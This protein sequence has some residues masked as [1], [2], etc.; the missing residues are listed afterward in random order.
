ML[1]ECHTP[2]FFR[3]LRSRQM[4]AAQSSILES[5]IP[6]RVCYEKNGNLQTKK[7]TKCKATISTLSKQH[8]LRWEAEEFHR[9]D[10]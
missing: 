8:I 9:H 6:F 3:Y 4:L 7:T 10:T 2:Y 1:R 5:A